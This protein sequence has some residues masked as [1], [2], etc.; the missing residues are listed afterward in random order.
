M[1]RSPQR[2]RGIKYNE[3]TG[4]FE[5]DTWAST[6]LLFTLSVGAMALMLRRE[7]D[8]DGGGTISS[9]LV[10]VLGAFC[11][12][13]TELGMSNTSTQLAFLCVMV[14]S[15]LIYNYY[16][17][18][19]V[20]VRLSEPI[21]KMNDS[22]VQLA[23]SGFRF[24]SE[25]VVYFDF[26]MKRPESEV[27]FFYNT[28]WMPIPD[29][30]KFMSL[31]QAVAKVQAGGFAYHTHPENFYPYVERHFDM[32]AICELTEVHVLRPQLNAFGVSH[33]STFTQLAR[34]G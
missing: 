32:R 3:I 15:L 25:W 11:Q 5:L 13:G 21:L 33:N 24:A 20:A 23:R 8:Y 28:I 9:S 29:A 7:P 16:G 12:Q 26:F 4:P 31:S 30:D 19:I 22:L 2:A 10:L 27:L 1:F 17:A 18:V 6:A 34:V 14:A